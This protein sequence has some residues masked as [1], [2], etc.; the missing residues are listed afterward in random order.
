MPANAPTLPS[1]AVAEMSAELK[2]L[3]EL[4]GYH[5]ASSKEL[6]L[7]HARLE[8]EWL[9]LIGRHKDEILALEHALKTTLASLEELARQH[10]EW[11]G[12]KRQLKT[13]V[14][15][16]KFTA[17]S[18]LSIPDPYRTIDKLFKRADRVAGFDATLYMT[19][20]TKLDK[21]VL[22]KLPKEVLERIG[23]V[24]VEGDSFS[25]KPLIVDLKRALADSAPSPE[26]NAA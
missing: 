11:F 1:P 24:V 18:S 2:R 5:A 22:E 23:V 9:A 14:G 17:T 15:V 20:D 8:R 16:I 10:P 12:E 26:Q 7:I 3:H 25:F 4:C 19:T 13:P 6:S 21:E